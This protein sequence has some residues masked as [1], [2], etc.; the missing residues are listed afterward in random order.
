MHDQLHDHLQLGEDLHIDET[1]ALKD[2]TDRTLASVNNHVELHLVTTTTAALDHAKLALDALYATLDRGLRKHVR[3]KE[4]G[5][6]D[7]AR[8][9][10]EDATLKAT[11]L[12]RLL[13]DLRETLPTIS[14]CFP[15]TLSASEGFC[16]RCA[17]PIDENCECRC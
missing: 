13:N 9:A 1:E 7:D 15:E 3:A 10:V 12:V 5:V 14:A 2:R 16:S 8:S 4:H 11:V 17:G 6:D